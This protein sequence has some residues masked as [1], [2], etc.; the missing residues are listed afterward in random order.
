MQGLQRCLQAMTADR[1]TALGLNGSR[2]PAAQ[3]IPL[4]NGPTKL[5]KPLQSLTASEEH[6]QDARGLAHQIATPA[7]QVNLMLV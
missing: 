7:P 2:Q 6:V 3:H 1:S 4:P 5:R